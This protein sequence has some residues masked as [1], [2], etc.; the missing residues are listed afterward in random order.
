MK[1]NAACSKC[2]R[3]M[4]GAAWLQAAAVT[5]AWA[6]PFDVP[7]STPDI[8]LLGSGV[9]L[10]VVLAFRLIRS[11]SAH[12]TAPQGTDLRWWKNP[13]EPR[14]DVNAMMFPR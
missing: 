2:A 12:L 11:H 4:A 13:P 10:I 8:L 14:D 3:S 1:S 9:V 7:I 5:P 6:V